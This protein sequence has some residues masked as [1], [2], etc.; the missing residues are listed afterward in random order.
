[1]F[2]IE[3]LK[4]TKKSIIKDMVKKEEELQ[5]NIVHNVKKRLVWV[6]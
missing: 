5:K 6:F 3:I 1:M 2:K 4:K